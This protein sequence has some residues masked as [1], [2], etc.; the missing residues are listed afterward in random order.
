MDRFTEVPSLKIPRPKV[1]FSNNY[2]VSTSDGGFPN[3]IY[4]AWNHVSYVDRGES[5]KYGWWGQGSHRF[6]CSI[7]KK[8]LIKL[9]GPYGMFQPNSF[10]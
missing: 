3:D 8:K 5:I 2:H 1:K 9:N 7:L 4:D 10:I 6:E